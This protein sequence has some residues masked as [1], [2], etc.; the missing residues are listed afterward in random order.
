MATE[1]YSS[2]LVFCDFDGTITDRNVGD[3]LYERYSASG[4]EMAER[5][6]RGEIGTRQEFELSFATVTASREE[7]EKTLAK[8]PF[9]EGF[10][11]IVELCRRRGHGLAII[12]EGLDW[13]IDAILSAHGIDGI[14]S[15]C[16]L[17]HF[18]R[19]RFRFEFPWFDDET[20]LRGVC[21]PKILRTLREAGWQLVY[22]GDGLSDREAVRVADVVYAKDHL[23]RYCQAEGIPATRFYT[24]AQVATQWRDPPGV[25]R[26]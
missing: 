13:Y 7:M 5:W 21:K 14:P 26:R 2:V 8:V 22:I 20:P 25:G 19:G 18:E 6:E 16:N 3:L 23:Y 17:I 1:Q 9:D 4:L 15:Y 11:Q 12:S 10:A 24:L